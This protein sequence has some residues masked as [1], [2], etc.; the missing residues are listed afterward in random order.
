MKRTKYFRQLADLYT[1]LDG[2]L[3]QQT[4]NTCGD[5]AVCCTSDGLNQH[6]VTAL[7]LDFIEEHVGPSKL[8]EFRLFLKRDGE[9][10]ICPYYDKGCTIYPHRPYSCRVFGHFRRKDTS[11]PEVC[12]FRG[13]EK[14]FGIGE[15]RD[16]VPEGEEL[17]EL[18]RYYWAH[19]KQRRDI[20]DT[21]YQAAGLEDALGKALEKLNSGDVSSALEEMEH[22]EAEDPFTLYSKSLILEEAGRPVLACS[23]LEQ[24]LEQ[25]PE[26]PDLW[27]RLGCSLFALGDREASERAFHRVVRYHPEHGQAWGLLGMHRLLKADFEKATSCLEKAVELLPGNTCLLYTS[28][29]PRDRQKSRMPSSA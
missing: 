7:E 29:S 13:Q 12:V 9:I 15:Y 24:A 3:P 1:R 19:R 25:A 5:C 26:S 11:L 2:E 17:I 23:L 21:T 16:T 27:H 8:D 14:I 10:P 18:S 4:G 22:E 28:P 20:D 6:N